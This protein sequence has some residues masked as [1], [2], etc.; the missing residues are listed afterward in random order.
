MIYT[1][2]ILSGL[3]TISGFLLKHLF[4]KNINLKNDLKISDKIIDMQRK[5]AK[6]NEVLTK[7][8]AKIDKEIQRKKNA[9]KKLSFSDKI[10]S[11]NNRNSGNK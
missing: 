1:I 10:K 5:A 6:D 2:T 3:L 4:K 11:A 7:E 8:Y 9:K